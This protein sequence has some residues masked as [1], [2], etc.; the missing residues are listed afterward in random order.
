MY[1]Q[2]QKNADVM[3][4]L[5]SCL[6]KLNLR[7]TFLILTLVLPMHTFIITLRC[8]GIAPGLP[9]IVLDH[10][11]FWVQLGGPVVHSFEK[12]ISTPDSKG[13]AITYRPT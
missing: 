11:I 6:Y 13:L 1:M 4:M 8:L 7:C 3:L 9:H 5:I 12:L 10:Q 2:G